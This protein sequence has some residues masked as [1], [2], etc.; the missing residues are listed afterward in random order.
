M[1]NL[2]MQAILS[3]E[4]TEHTKDLGLQTL[5]SHSLQHNTV[6]VDLCYARAM[7]GTV[8]YSTCGSY[9]VTKVRPGHSSMFVV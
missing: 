2:L 9:P 7:R 1:P 4:S 6:L 8:T 5:L 3:N